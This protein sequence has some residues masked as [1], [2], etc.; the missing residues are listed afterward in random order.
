MLLCPVDALELEVRPVDVVRVHRD[1]KGVDGGG[2]EHLRSSEISLKIIWR[3]FRDQTGSEMRDSTDLAVGAV[4]GDP[5]DD[6][7]H[8][9]REVDHVLV[10]V[11]GEPARL[12]QVRVHDG[13]LQ[14]QL[15]RALN[16][17]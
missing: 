7:A 13:L 15:N 6:L 3:S 17:G 10:V 5:L 4:D 8:G 12:L 16:I 11:D 1:G 2:E 14:V 9:V